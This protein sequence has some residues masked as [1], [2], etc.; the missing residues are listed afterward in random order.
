[1]HYLLFNAVRSQ[2]AALIKVRSLQK[3]ENEAMTGWTMTELINFRL[4][5]RGFNYVSYF[6]AVKKVLFYNSHP[7]AI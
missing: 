2:K 3:A 4:N 5:D 1:M 7:T 6:R